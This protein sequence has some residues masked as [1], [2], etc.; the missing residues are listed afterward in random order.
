MSRS[1]K[2]YQSAKKRH[3]AKM[4]E[5]EDFLNFND[6][7][8]NSE[9]SEPT[10]EPSMTLDEFVN[11]SIFS[12]ENCQRALLALSNNEELSLEDDEMKVK[13]SSTDADVATIDYNDGEITLTFVKKELTA[14]FQEIVDGAVNENVD[15]MQSVL[16]FKQYINLIKI[17][18]LK[19]KQ[20]HRDPL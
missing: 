20:N 6:F 18:Y 7:G 8:V 12:V 1:S 9:I 17:D 5:E 16:K 2:I 11:L 13:I 15:K 14:A 10:N 3:L 19:T 4:N